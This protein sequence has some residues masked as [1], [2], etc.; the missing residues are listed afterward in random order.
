LVEELG[1][2]MEESA[3]MLFRNQYDE[4]VLSPKSR[5]SVKSRWQ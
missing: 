5:W 2:K 1:E 4:T 3:K